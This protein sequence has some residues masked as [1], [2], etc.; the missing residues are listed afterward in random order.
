MGHEDIIYFRLGAY[1]QRP[2]HRQVG[3][4]STPPP[5]GRHAVHDQDLRTQVRPGYRL[6]GVLL[7]HEGHPPLLS[8]LRASSASILTRS[9]SGGRLLGFAALQ[10]P[11]RRLSICFLPSMAAWSHNGRQVKALSPQPLHT[12]LLFRRSV[13]MAKSMTGRVTGRRFRSGGLRITNVG[14]LA[15]PYLYDAGGN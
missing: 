12:A 15:L 11:A 1:S 8:A 2:T 6:P 7:S 5:A 14:G 10:D 3:V 13:W 4:V 9:L